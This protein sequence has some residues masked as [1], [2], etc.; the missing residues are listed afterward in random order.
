MGTSVYF[1]NQGA[2]REQ[3]LIEDMIIE[4]IKNHGIDVYYIPRESQSELDALFGDDPVKS[5][6][7]AYSLEMYL[8]SFQDFEGNQEFFSKFGLQIQ[9]EARVAVARRTFEK[10][11]PTAVRNVPKEG[12]L[13]Y[14]RVQKKILEI[15]FVEEEKNFF[16]LGKSAPY[17]YGLNLEVFRYNG[18]RL[19]TGIEEID[20]IADMNA[21][22][23][24]FTMNN[25]GYNTFTNH[26]IVFQGASLETATAKGYVSGWDLPT[27]KLIIRN[28]K[29]SFAANA[30]VYGTVSGAQWIML[31]GNPQEN[32]T[33]AFDDNVRIENE[34]DNILDWTE[35]NP[36]GTIDENY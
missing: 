7:T 25:S 24:E 15:K 22:G 13:I 5:F 4:S 19:I 12:D 30:M 18:E 16:Q 2:T 26:E 17:M 34:A 31:S 32:I 20:N 21:Y 10:N 35:T 36:F 9:K 11:I 14:L 28:I 8:E 1:N 27:K 33:E 3:V 6:S 23:I 29:G